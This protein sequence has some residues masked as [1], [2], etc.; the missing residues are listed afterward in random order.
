MGS[1]STQLRRASIEAALDGIV[2]LNPGVVGCSR[3]QLCHV[4]LDHIRRLLE[5]LHAHNCVGKR[6]RI[7][8]ALPEGLLEVLL[9]LVVLAQEHIARGQGV[10][11][12]R[13]RPVLLR[14]VLVDIESILRLG[15]ALGDHH[16]RRRQLCERVV[17]IHALHK[18]YLLVRK[19]ESVHA[20]V[21]VRD[22]GMLLKRLGL[23]RALECLLVILVVAE[24]GRGR[25]GQL[26][27]DRGAGVSEEAT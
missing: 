24:Q 4:A 14:Q 7:R 5:V 27:V 9:R 18:G 15:G 6:S 12:L 20:D 23:V 8:G 26:S 2:G 1:S 19:I 10:E 11:E 22:H 17:V 16:T 21:D 3:A 13:R 25:H